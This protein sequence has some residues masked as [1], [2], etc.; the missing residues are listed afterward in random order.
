MHQIATLPRLV[1][2]P[3]QHAKLK[4]HNT[5]RHNPT[6]PKHGKKKKKK[7]PNSINNFNILIVSHM[8]EADLVM[9]N[10]YIE[11]CDANTI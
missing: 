10:D 5:S 11:L 6:N 2:R 7:I 8:R 9:R 3:C 1:N 4:L